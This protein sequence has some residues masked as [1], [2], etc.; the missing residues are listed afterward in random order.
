MLQT[1]YSDNV[2]SENSFEELSLIIRIPRFLKKHTHDVSEKVKK[3]WGIGVLKQ[4]E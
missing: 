1:H 3:G 2:S 4:I